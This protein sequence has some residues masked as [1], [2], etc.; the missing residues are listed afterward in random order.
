M[1]ILLV[2]WKVACGVSEGCIIS[3]REVGIS[4]RG[5]EHKVQSRYRSL[6]CF[7]DPFELNMTFIILLNS[8]THTGIQNGHDMMIYCIHTQAHTHMC[9]HIKVMFHSLLFLH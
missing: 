3:S 1:I 5:I 9:R 7:Y 6:T 4:L 2:A 8:L